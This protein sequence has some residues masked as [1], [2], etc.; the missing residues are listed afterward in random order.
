MR[1]GPSVSYIL[2]VHN[3]EK[4]LRSTVAALLERL[5]TSPGSEVIM[6]ENGSTDSSP[7]LV[8]RLEAELGG[9]IVAVLAA[10]S[11]KGFGNALRR[12]MELAGGDL[13]MLTAA[14]LPFGF[15]DLDAALELHDRPPVVVGSKGH[16]QSVV[17]ASLLR[18]V[19]SFGFRLLRHAALGLRVRDSQG[20][21]LVERGLLATLRPSL[22]SDDYLLST[23]LIT[24]AARKGAAVVEV[25]VVYD[26]PRS[27]SR[28]R[29]VRDSLRMAA[30]ILALRRRLRSAP[31][32]RPGDRTPL[33]APSGAPDAEFLG[34]SA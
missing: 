7:A 3:E 5:S 27:D 16:A 18:R 26:A 31:A 6:V 9:G 30:G 1:S 23:E 32:L 12:G 15:S 2:P 29:P 33:P 19:M 13:V 24:L 17:A 22:E 20:T 11:A 4:I 25:P 8:R 28:I 14:D 10:T 34:A 21:I